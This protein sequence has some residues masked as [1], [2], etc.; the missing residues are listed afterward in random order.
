MCLY[1]HWLA[2]LSTFI[3]PARGLF[4]CH[5]QLQHSSSS[6][7]LLLVHDGTGRC[8]ADSQL[9]QGQAASANTRVTPRGVSRLCQA[10]C[11]AC[12]HM[13]RDTYHVSF[14][15]K[16]WW[17]FWFPSTL[18]L[19]H[20]CVYNSHLYERLWGITFFPKCLFAH[21]YRVNSSTHKAVLGSCVF[22][23]QKSLG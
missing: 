20:H 19:V 11:A 14:I 5:M 12:A 22:S 15:H 9:S 21:S 4:I 6:L 8:G 2:F 18:A 16:Q 23:I 7:A 13:H 17:A 10:R 1:R 3:F